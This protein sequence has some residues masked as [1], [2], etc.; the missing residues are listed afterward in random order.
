MPEGWRFLS[1]KMKGIW[2]FLGVIV[3]SEHEKGAIHSC[4]SV[5]LM[6]DDDVALVVARIDFVADEEVSFR[7]RIQRILVESLVGILERNDAAIC[8]FGANGI[9]NLS[10]GR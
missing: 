4:G 8:S 6:A 10:N 9:K 7:Q 3:D 5:G 1:D 2:Q